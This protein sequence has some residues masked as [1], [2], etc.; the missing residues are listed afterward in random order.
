MRIRKDLWGNWVW[1]AFWFRCV[2][3]RARPGTD[4]SL[5]SGFL[6]QVPRGLLKQCLDN[7]LD[8]TLTGF[9][10]WDHSN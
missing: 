3:F 7:E 8:G 5:Q 1:P 10:L 6:L 2:P 9:L 4:S